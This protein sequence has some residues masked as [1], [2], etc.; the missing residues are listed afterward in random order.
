MRTPGRVVKI[1]LSCDPRK[2]VPRRSLK[3]KEV[4]INCM[5]FIKLHS[6]VVA[7]FFRLLV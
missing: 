6:S 4:M 1:R 7:F 5:L 2:E 3:V